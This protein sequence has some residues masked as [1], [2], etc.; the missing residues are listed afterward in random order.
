MFARICVAAGLPEPEPEYRFA[1]PQRWRFDWALP[2]HKVALEV[3]GG[4]WTQG[5][6]TR[7]KG[8]VNDMAKYNA[9]VL[10]GWKVLR[11][12]P[13]ELLTKGPDLLK[14]ALQG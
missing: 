11:V 13:S 5:R 12:T 7:G 2:Q 14:A 4:A 10:A 1:A 9:A 6:H 8:F 3:E